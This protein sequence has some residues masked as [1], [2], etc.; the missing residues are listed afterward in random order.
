MLG[1]LHR[2]IDRS[3]RANAGPVHRN[4]DTPRPTIRIQKRNTNV[5]HFTNEQHTTVAGIDVFAQAP[6]NA[7]YKLCSEQLTLIIS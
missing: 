3:P 1:V 7:G 2:T 5:V 6:N 4:P